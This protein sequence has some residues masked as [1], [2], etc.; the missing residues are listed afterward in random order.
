[1]S[2]TPTL[3]VFAPYDAVCL[4]E[5]PLSNATEVEQALTTATATFQQREKWLSVPKRIA[6]LSKFAALITQHG[7]DLIQ[8]ACAE[9]G[10]PL[11]DSKIEHIRCVDSI[12]ICIDSLRTQTA[13]PVHMGSNAASMNRLITQSLEPIGV[14]VAVSAFNHPLNLIAHQVSPAVAAGCPVIIK[15]AEDTPLSCLALVKLLHQAGLAK[16]WC[17][18]VMPESIALAQ[19][20]VTDSRVAFFSFI[21]SAKVGWYLRSQ[22]AAGTRCALEHGGSAPVIVEKDVDIAAILPSLVKGAFYH[23]GQVCVSVQRVFVHRSIAQELAQAMTNA[24]LSLKVGN[25]LDEAT[26]VGPLIRAGEVQRVDTWVQEAVAA[27]AEL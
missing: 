21:G 3:K 9:G 27:G 15:P 11:V 10:K 1:M 19:T 2:S 22:L 5:V 14:V 25:P 23:A 4:G 7:D 24:A 18:M 17:Q 26:Q 6:I 20:M 8:T 12:Q 16:A 13:E